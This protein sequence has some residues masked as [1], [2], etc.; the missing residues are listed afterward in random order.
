MIRSFSRPGACH[1]ISEVSPAWGM[2]VPG[3]NPAGGAAL[4]QV[5]NQTRVMVTMMP[6][7]LLT[8]FRL[9]CPRHIGGGGVVS[10]LRHGPAFQSD[11]PVWSW[12]I[13]IRPPCT[14]HSPTNSANGGADIRWIT[15]LAHDLSLSWSRIPFTAPW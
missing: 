1:V 12:R 13:V 3:S 9:V 14:D 8:S 10:A 4:A 6:L 15:I 11:S 2:L 7:G 5:V